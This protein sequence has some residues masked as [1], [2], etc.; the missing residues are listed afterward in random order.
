MTE[1][2]LGSIITASP[3][4]PSEGYADSTA[5]GVWNVHDPLLF[6]RAGDWPDPTNVSPS[7][8]IENVFSTYTYAGTG[9]TLTINNGIDFSNSGGLLWIKNRE[10][11]GGYAQDHSLID[12]ERGH[13]IALKSNS[14]SGNTTQEYALGT[15]G[16]FNSNGF[17]QASTNNQVNASGTPYISWSFRKQPKFFDVV[18]Y[19]GNG[20]TDRDI[21]HSL[22][23][24]PGMIWIKRTDSSE[25]WI[26]YHRSLHQ[27][28]GGTAATTYWSKLELDS[29]GTQYGATRL[30]GSGAGEDH[31][32]T[33]FHVS[34]HA[35]VNANTGTYV[36]YIFAHNNDDGG[37][38]STGDQDI[39][40]CGSYTGNGSSSNAI[41]LGFEPQW[42]MIKNATATANWILFDIIRGIS[43]GDNDKYVFPDANSA[44]GSF[45]GIEVTA[46]GFR[47]ASN[48]ATTNNS[49]QT[50]IYVAIR[51]GPIKVPTA[52]KDVLA[53][54]K[55]TSANLNQDPKYL[56]TSGFP[57]DFVINK[58]M[59][60]AS[61]FWTSSRLTNTRVQLE[62]SDAESAALTTHEFDHMTGVGVAGLTG[63]SNFMGYMFRRQPKVFDIV[64]YA[65]TGSATTVKHNLEVTPELILI[66]GRNVAENW[67]VYSRNDATDH[68]HLNT[69]DATADED[70]FFNDTAPTSSVFTVG[71]EDE[72]NGS[73]NYIAYL[74]ATLAGV[75]KEGTYSGTG[76]DV[77]VDCGFTSG[78]RFVIAKRTDSSGDWY[79]WDSE[80]TIVAGNDP[81]LV[82][83]T[84]AAQVTNTDYIDPLSSGFTITSGAP[85]ALNASGGTYLFLAIA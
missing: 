46:D 50:Y 41:T 31:T 28:G 10:N 8:F 11:V 70:G 22:G 79:L 64:A 81:Y 69:T 80:R 12:T 58:L 56:Q 32:T 66:K 83:N 42:I 6:N 60:D 85:D 84:N 61:S 39:I 1:R 17:T 35:S 15:N 65:G 24:E 68:L 51:R 13:T 23:S 76:S 7:K 16:S 40:K 45:E 49:S 78:A 19:T 4:E 36:A 9:S 5:S 48:N 62:T 75:S 55:E 3:T 53:I 43:T 27:G 33:T 18:T 59:N 47:I 73:Y 67:V 52:G 72:V 21:S 57:V 25:S 14:T 34:S 30:W 82:V 37:F 44:E 38:G 63:D 20:A 71:D 2:Y 77:N 29:T 54:L 26:V 74:F